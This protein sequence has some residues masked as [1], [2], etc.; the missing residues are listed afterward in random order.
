MRSEIQRARQL[1]RNMSEPEVML[2][3]RLMRLRER[4]YRIRR[5]MPFRGYFLDFV[6][7]S[8][9]LV[10][11][12]DGWQHGEEAQAEHDFVRDKILERE[13][14]TLIRVSAGEVRRNLG[15]VM[16]RIVLALEAQASTRG[17]GR[18]GDTELE[19]HFPT[20]AATRPVPP[21]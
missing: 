17:R 13:G 6:C 2:W 9:R 4:G 18:S 10:V 11:E 19:P 21:H 3:S 8:R 16:D 12:V 5:Q 15:Q 14:F 20:L 7:L 1:R